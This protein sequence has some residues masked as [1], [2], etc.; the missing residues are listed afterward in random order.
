MMS[1]STR[2][3][4]VTVLTCAFVLGGCTRAPAGSPASGTGGPSAHRT[5]TATRLWP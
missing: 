4:A 2:V 1:P 3:V 5:L